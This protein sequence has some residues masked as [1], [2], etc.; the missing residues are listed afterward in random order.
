VVEAD[1]RTVR[2]AANVRGLEGDDFVDR[3]GEALGFPITLENDINLAALGEQWRGVARGVSDFAF[4]S[5][6]TGL[7]AGLVL[8]GRLHRGQHGAAGEVDYV[9]AGMDER[10]DPSGPALSEVAA[11]EAAASRSETLLL[12]PYDARTV[13]A[14]A[15]AGDGVA[16]DVVRE[17]ARR[18]ARHIAPL[19]AVADVGLVVLG[20]GI[21]VN[22]DLLL[23]DVRRLLGEWLPYPPRVD[24]SRLGDAAV[25]TG[26]VSVALHAALDNVFARHAARTA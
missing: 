8:G 5:V 21:G 26:A 16:L 12:P 22:A 1:G 17:E 18:I 13:F 20:G 11:A 25:L 9:A 2:L 19:A 7:G 23:D 14:A 3:A 6:G 10:I 15:R 4:L 24:V